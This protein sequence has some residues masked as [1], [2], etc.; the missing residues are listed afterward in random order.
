ML[1]LRAG[2]F[3]GFGPHK[4]QAGQGAVGAGLRSFGKRRVNTT[5]DLG[6]LPWIG[7]EDCPEPY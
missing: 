3:S 1:V 4:S 6:F 7:C 2:Q 5:A